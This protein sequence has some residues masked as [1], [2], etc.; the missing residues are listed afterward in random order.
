LEL[1]IALSNIALDHIG[2]ARSFYQYAAQLIGEGCTEDTLAY[3]RKEREFRNLLIVELP[4]KDFAFTLAKC[5]CLDNF[6]QLQYT[7]LSL[8]SDETIAGIAAKSLKEV[9]YHVRFSSD[10]ALRLGD[11]TPESKAKL[12]QAIDEIWIYSGEAF[13]ASEAEKELLEKNIAIDLSAIKT[14]WQ[15]NISNLLD[16]ATLLLPTITH[17]HKGGKEGLHTEHLGLILPELQYMQRTYP[18]MEW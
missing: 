2:A 3:F 4:N 14:K 10:W 8:S 9:N 11:G 12:Q 1:D 15:N 16:N 17:A 5:I 6:L 7:A 18:N 13:I